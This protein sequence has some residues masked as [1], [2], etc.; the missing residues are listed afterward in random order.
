MATSSKL[1]VMISSRN[2]NKFPSNGVEL[3]TIRKELKKELEDLKI[4]GKT[5]LKVWINED[6][7]SQGADQTSWDVCMKAAR[8]CDVLI[9][10]YSEDAGWK[11]TD[12]DIGICHAELKEGLEHA[13]AKVHLI[14]L[15]N[16]LTK[17]PQGQ[18]NELFRQYVKDQRFFEKE[19]STEDELKKFVKDTVRNAILR[20]AQRGV[21]EASK[22]KSYRGQALSWSELSFEERRKSITKAL[23]QSILDRTNSKKMK[24]KLTIKIGGKNI[25]VVLDAIPASLSIGAAKELVGQPF[26]QDYKLAGVLKK[27][28]VGPIHIIGCNKNVTETQAMKILGFPDAAVINAPFGVF[29]ADNIQ[30][31]QITFIANCRDESTTRYGLQRFI[32][33]ISETGED[34]RIAER[35]AAR[36]RIIKVI[37]K[38]ITP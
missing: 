34:V 16:H 13:P 36:E 28:V 8:E 7:P 11:L 1:M 31:I 17:L 37:A 2:R 9:S 32:E 20:L 12:G 10:L 19:A 23:E 15:K 25:L 29:V 3:S 33:W 21:T 5:F 26:L 14:R 35:G 4:F 30:K 6:Q 38:E 18:S 27:S 24:S 22:G